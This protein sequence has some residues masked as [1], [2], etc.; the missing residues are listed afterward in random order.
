[1][2]CVWDVVRGK[3]SPEK[4]PKLEGVD[5][6]WVHPTPEAS[7]NACQR[8]FDIY[9][10]VARPSLTSR[11]IT[12]QAVDMNINWHGTIEVIDGNGNK[13]LLSTDRGTEM[14]PHLW[15]LGASYGVHKLKSDP[16]HW[17]TDG[18]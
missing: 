9:G 18:R 3:V 11:H 7:L 4:L 2:R 12:G 1:M 8:M 16:P 13:V 15:A 14:N 17:S 5:I 6:D 10:L